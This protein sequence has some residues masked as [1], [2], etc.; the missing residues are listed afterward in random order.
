MPTLIY[1]VATSLDGFIARADGGLDWL[2]DTHQA[3]QDYGYAAFY[4]SV[5]A[6]LMGSETWRTCQGF[7]SWPYSGKPTVVLSRD[8]ALKPPQAQ[9]SAVHNSPGE[10]LQALAQQGHER[11]WLVGG[12]RLA[13]NC[14][15]AGLIDELVISII[16]RL[17]GSGVPLFA[18]CIERVLQLLEVR[19]FPNGV[20]QQRYRILRDSQ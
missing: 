4:A 6:L 15:A 8:T 5:D 11:I 1:Y 14:L 17:L 19:A 7:D 9:V 20:I 16:P 3:D 2:D 18:G 12:G 13:G 10:A